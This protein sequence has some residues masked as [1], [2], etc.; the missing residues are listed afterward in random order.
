VAP[1][2]A[3][4]E[5]FV[6]LRRCAVPVCGKRGSGRGRGCS[7]PPAKATVAAQ[8]AG[9]DEGRECSGSYCDASVAAPSPRV[10]GR[11]SSSSYCGSPFPPLTSGMPAT[12]THGT[13]GWQRFR[14][15]SPVPPHGGRDRVRWLER[16]KHP[17][18]RDG[19][20]VGSP[21]GGRCA[22][23]GRDSAASTKAMGGTQGKG[24]R[25]SHSCDRYHLQRLVCPQRHGS[26]RRRL[27]PLR[28]R[29]F[30]RLFRRHHCFRALLGR[31]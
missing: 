28:G 30:G 10:V 14:H 7:L 24:R 23:L 26:T 18:V 19:I 16:L 4:S 15:G 27:Q 8:R 2:A 5:P 12:R 13:S 9:G 11:F 20:V 21:F 29:P 3:I 31:L 1:K 6:L 17:P 25:S 22:E